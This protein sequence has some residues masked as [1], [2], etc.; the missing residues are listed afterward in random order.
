[1]TFAQSINFLESVSMGMHNS[2]PLIKR[3][4]GNVLSA[5][6]FKKRVVDEWKV[7][8]NILLFFVVMCS[9]DTNFVF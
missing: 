3:A 1:M 8:N 9:V 2:L 5:Q 6:F 7:D 4:S